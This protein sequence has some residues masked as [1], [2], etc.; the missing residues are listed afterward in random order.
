MRFHLFCRKRGYNFHLPFVLLLVGAVVFLSACQISAKNRSPSTEEIPNFIP[1][2]LHITETPLPT[3]NTIKEITTGWIDPTLPRF[4]IDQVTT[5]FDLEFVEFKDEAAVRFQS[6]EGDL[7]GY[8]TYVAAVPI[9]SLRSD[10]QSIDLL[11]YWQGNP[12]SDQDYDIT[13]VLSSETRD[14]LASIIGPPSEENVS[15]LKNQESYQDYWEDPSI[16][17]IF[18]FDNISPDWTILAID[19]VDPLSADFEQDKYLLTIPI[20][21][22]ADENVLINFDTDTNFSNYDTGKLSSI[23]L[24]GVTAMVRDTAAIMEELGIT[25]PAS[26]IFPLLKNASITH[27]SNEVPFAEDCPSP[28][29]NQESL[30][31]CSKDSYIELLDIVGADIIEVS[32]DHFADWGPEAMLHTL[33]LYDQRG[34]QY[35][36]GGKNLQ[37]G[38]NP[39]FLEHNGNTFAFIGCNGKAHEKYATASET[40]PGAS[41]CQYDWMIDEIKRLMSEGFIVIATLQHEEVDSYH[42]IALQQYDFGRLAEAG[43]TIVSGSQ[44]HHPQ[45]FEYTGSTFIHYGLGNLF[46]D[47]WYLANY[48]PADHANKDKSIIDFHYFYDN[49]YINTRFITMQFIDNAKPR[50]MTEDERELFLLEIYRN[51]LWNEQSLLPN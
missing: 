49:E 29:P 26:D 36:G 30:Y 48:N 8:W 50:L 2:T 4:L 22:S 43:A 41:R 7:L 44:S 24:T 1:P 42:S 47:Q 9:H 21:I 17:V 12:Q 28:D 19:N 20:R 25:Y 23:A 27:I 11:D 37:E 38:L 35:Y 3:Q 32:G 14:S 18:P 5:S 6:S 45:G 10:L 34:W 33:E 46:F 39:I 51:S 15:V 40:N 13:I 31:F 16:L